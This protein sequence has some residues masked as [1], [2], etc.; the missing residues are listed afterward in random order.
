MWLATQIFGTSELTVRLPALLGATLYITAS[1]RLCRLLSRSLV[2]Q[3]ALFVCLVYN[4][5]IFDYLVTARGYA[6]AL[7]LLMWAIVA[8][9][10]AGHAL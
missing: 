3:L 4:P 1:Y 8:P 6:L 10:T 7:G 5:F 2:L 9:A